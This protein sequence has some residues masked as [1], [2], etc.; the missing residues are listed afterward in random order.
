MHGTGDSGGTTAVV[1]L[2][3]EMATCVGVRPAPRLRM[4]TSQAI[5]V[6]RLPVLSFSA[7]GSPL[8][9]DFASREWRANSAAF[10]GRVGAKNDVSSY[11]FA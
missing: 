6:S 5:S 7:V 2:S 1:V 8:N 3:E 11:Q 4:P 9:L 10:V